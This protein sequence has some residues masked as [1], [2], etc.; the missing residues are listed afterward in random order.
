VPGRQQYAALASLR[1][2]TTRGIDR[3]TVVESDP[4]FAPIRNTPGFREL[5]REM[6]QRWIELAHRRGYTT[7]AELRMLGMAHVV[8]G[9]LAQAVE[10]FEG[11]L[12]AGGPQ[13]DVVRGEL[14]EAR[15]RLARGAESGGPG[16]AQTR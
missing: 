15:A 8:R 13:D 6:A 5:V 2:A 10:A 9:E 11:A 1:I 14:D 7:Q 16:G 4:G 12:A 3:F